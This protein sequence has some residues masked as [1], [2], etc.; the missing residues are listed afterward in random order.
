MVKYAPLMLHPAATEFPR[1]MTLIQWAGLPEDEPGEFVDGR[2]EEDVE[3][4]AL[5]CMLVSLISSMHG[6]AR[7]SPRQA[8]AR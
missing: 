6:W 4:T 3:Q 5:H 7:N 2:L 1:R 8:R